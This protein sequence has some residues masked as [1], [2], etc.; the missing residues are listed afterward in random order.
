LVQFT[1]RDLE[2]GGL[3]YK[4][5]ARECHG[6]WI[7]FCSTDIAFHSP[8]Q[9]FS[10]GQGV[11]RSGQFFQFDQYPGFVFEYDTFGDQ[12]VARTSRE[13]ARM[14]ESYKFN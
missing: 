12:I 2:R 4:L 6:V 10:I 7:S 9:L 13:A 5:C 8:L 11:L 1:K 14:L 3:I